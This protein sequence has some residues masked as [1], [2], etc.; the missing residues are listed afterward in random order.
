MAEE[1]E[2]EK[3]KGGGKLV[4]I[5]LVV[6]VVLLLAVV[7]GGAAW[8]LMGNKDKP[9]EEGD[10]HAPEATEQPVKPKGPAVY[11]PL[12]M[13]LT[14]NFADTSDANV[15]QVEVQLVTFDPLLADA[16]K[17]HAPEI[18][19]NLIMLFSE[20]KAAELRTREGKDKLRKAALEEVRGVLKNRADKEGVED[21]LFTRFVMQ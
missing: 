19:N 5:L 12:G 1:A 20:Q 14:V 21:L 7:G 4:L 9:A 13:P 2:G 16:V 6:V 8:F 10:G 11:I 15:M 18:T 17:A 3:K